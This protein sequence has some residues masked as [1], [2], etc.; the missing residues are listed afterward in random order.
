MICAVRRISPRMGPGR[1]QPPAVRASLPCRSSSFFICC[2]D[3]LRA[4][5][6][7]R[8]LV[9]VRVEVLDHL[10]FGLGDEPEAGAVAGQ[11]G[12]RADRERPG[13]PERSEQAGA[14]VEVPHPLL[15]PG[16]VVGLLAG[17]GQQGCRAARGLRAV[18]AWP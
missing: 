13:V 12:Q 1:S 16:E 15:A 14:A 10:F 5:V 3:P 8:Q 18:S 6:V 4:L 7:H 17:R 11:A 9:Q 2:D